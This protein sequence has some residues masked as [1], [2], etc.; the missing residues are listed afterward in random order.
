MAGEQPLDGQNH[1]RRTEAALQA[2]AVFERRLHWMQRA[3]LRE[4][5]N[6]GDFRALGLYRED[7]AGFD[8]AAV[9]VDRAGAALSRVAADVR[10]CQAE[11]V[12]QILDKQG[13]GVD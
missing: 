1:S 10:A 12:A 2:V 13:A 9:Q 5:F 11:L 3:V 6:G 8:R 7:V 4:S